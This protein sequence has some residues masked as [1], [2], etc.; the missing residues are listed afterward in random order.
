M[1]VPH[2]DVVYRLDQL[3]RQVAEAIGDT[4]P[5]RLDRGLLVQ[6]INSITD[7]LGAWDFVNRNLSDAERKIDRKERVI[8]G[9]HSWGNTQNTFTSKRQ[10][11]GIKAV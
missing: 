11:S 5:A 10:Q 8:R 1:Q 7:F 4:V 3:Q 2:H 9:L 6:L